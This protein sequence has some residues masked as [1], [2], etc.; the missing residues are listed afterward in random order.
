MDE[1]G[2]IRKL[3]KNDE[4]FKQKFLQHESELHS[5]DETEGPNGKF[6][7]NLPDNVNP[8]HH[9][10]KNDN[11]AAFQHG[12]FSLYWYYIKTFGVTK[13]IIWLILTAMSSSLERIPGIFVR[14]WFSVDPG[15]KLYFIGY[16]SIALTATIFLAIMIV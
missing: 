6:A 8:A 7:T 9:L 15:N 16:A 1:H 14:I 10:P 2:R 3:D 13:A 5:E 11:Q 12:D 4:V